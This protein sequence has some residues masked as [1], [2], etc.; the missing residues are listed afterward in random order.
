MGN[1]FVDEDSVNSLKLSLWNHVSVDEHR[2]KSK[3]IT[4]LMKG[5]EMDNI[6]T[7]IIK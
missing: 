7:I 5:Q 6:I 3:S 4:T 2:L 1:F